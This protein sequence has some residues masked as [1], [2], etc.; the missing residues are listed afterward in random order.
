LLLYFN[1]LSGEQLHH[2][3]QQL[4]TTFNTPKAHIPKAFA[5]A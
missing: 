4:A 3:S 2:V 1:N 5:R